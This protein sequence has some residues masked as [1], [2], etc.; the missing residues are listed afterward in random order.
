MSLDILYGSVFEVYCPF[1]RLFL[2]INKLHEG[3]LPSTA[4][5]DNWDKFSRHNW[6]IDTF[7]CRHTAGVNFCY[8]IKTNDW[9]IFVVSRHRKRYYCFCWYSYCNPL[10]MNLSKFPSRTAV[11]LLVSIPVRWSFTR[12]Y[13]WR[14]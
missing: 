12:V 7:K 10:S 4:G 5:A 6:N 14:V 13:G 1:R 3:R 2:G 9:L 8:I 11:A